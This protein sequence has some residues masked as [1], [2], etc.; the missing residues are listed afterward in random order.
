M[1]FL[2]VIGVGVVLYFICQAILLLKR[3]A[4]YFTKPILNYRSLGEWALVTGCTRGIGEAF[5]FELAKYGMDLFLVGRNEEKLENLSREL[6]IQHPNIKTKLFVMDFAKNDIIVYEGLKKEAEKMEIG[7]VINNVAMTPGIDNFHNTIGIGTLHKDTIKC[8]IFNLLKITQITLP[9]M[10]RRK[11]GIII[12]VASVAAI[13]V[14]GYFTLYA[15]TKRFIYNIS[16]ALQ[17]EYR[18]S[19]VHIQCVL[20]AMVRT[21]LSKFFGTTTTIGTPNPA[22]YT[23]ECLNACGTHENITGYWAHELQ[24]KFMQFVTPSLLRRLTTRLIL[25][26]GR[27]QS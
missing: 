4:L 7:V 6:K 21:Q 22:T 20:P 12:N 17:Y 2:S 27:N 19:G 1:G 24:I 11:N 13:Q 10:V 18:D 15:S 26:A 9:F 8:N 5:V 3:L 23:R 14:S 25:Q 16:Q